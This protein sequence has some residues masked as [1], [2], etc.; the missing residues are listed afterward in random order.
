MTPLST[1]TSAPKQERFGIHRALLSHYSSYFKAALTESF[2]ESQAG[3]I[4]LEDEDPEVFRAF[5]EWI[6]STVLSYQHYA[7]DHTWSTL[8]DLYVFAEK[9]IIP[10]L[11][12]AV[13]D[14]MIKYGGKSGSHP[15]TEIHLAWINT[16][17]SSPLHAF[18]AEFYARW[19]N[20]TKCFGQDSERR[21]CFDID[22]VMQ[23]AIALE[24]LTDEF[25]SG[26]ARLWEDRCLW[27]VHGSDDPGCTDDASSTSS[28]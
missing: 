15:G 27:H 8:L 23:V 3:V 5:N 24:S 1:S 11:Q 4:S 17:S 21:G 22:F 2:S 9:R 18:L 26:N 10:R 28:E 16:A 7:K 13:I 19:V 14:A 25:R 6:Y 12:N 20:L